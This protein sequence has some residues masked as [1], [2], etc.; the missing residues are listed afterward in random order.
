MEENQPG[1][2]VTGRMGTDDTTSIERVE[3]SS[4]VPGSPVHL[5]S[6]YCSACPGDTW[7][8]TK[9]SHLP[10]EEP[11]QVERDTTSQKKKKLKNV[12]SKA[13]LISEISGFGK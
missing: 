11:E 12:S 3:P 9:S 7:T 13:G 4:F 10:V 8:P 2:A 5:N 1:S 6:S